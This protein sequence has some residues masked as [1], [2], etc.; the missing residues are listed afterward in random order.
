MSVKCA[1]HSCCLFVRGN[2]AWRDVV[3]PC[4]GG[5]VGPFE[6]VGELSAFGY[7]PQITKIGGTKSL[8]LEGGLTCSV[9]TFDGLNVS[10]TVRCA[11]NGNLATAMF[12]Q[13]GA[14]TDGTVTGESI[15]GSMVSAGAY[16]PLKYVGAKNV[17]VVS[18]TGAVENVDYKVTPAG[19]EIIEGSTVLTDGTDMIVNYSYSTQGRVE[20]G[21]RNSVEKELLFNGKDQEGNAIVLRLY[22]VDIAADGEVQWLN[23]N[24]FIT[25]TISGTALVDETQDAVEFSPGLPRSQ[26]GYIQR[27]KA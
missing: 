25:F 7:T 26:F 21:T 15:D 12:G 5:G 24:D 27:I 2:L 19:L 14:V 11:S 22:R 17:V 23:E 18:P 4:S 13:H 3:D 9:S 8:S 16:V 10:M 20:I 1:S 6:K